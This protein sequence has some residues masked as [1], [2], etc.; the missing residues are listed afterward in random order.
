MPVQEVI[1]EKNEP[2]STADAAAGNKSDEPSRRG[3]TAAEIDT[4]GVV[5]V[6]LVLAIVVALWVNRS[7]DFLFA[8]RWRWEA[9]IG[10]VVLILAALAIPSTSR[11]LQ[12]KGTSVRA[13]LLFF[14]LIPALLMGYVGFIL[15]RPTYEFY[16]LRSLFLIVVILLPGVMFYL[17][18]LN[19][20]ISLLNLFIANL[21]GLGLLDKQVRRRGEFASYVRKFEAVY[22]TV[23]DETLMNAL[24]GVHD[25][26]DSRGLTDRVLT[27]ETGVP[28]V[29]ATLLIALGWLLVLP[30]K[31]APADTPVWFAALAVE[32]SP[33]N[34]AFL[35]AYFFALQMFFAISGPARTSPSRCASSCR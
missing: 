21:D 3:R 25:G 22:G 8:E 32:S 18:I 26:S 14:V 2:S 31:D 4:R 29:V 33:V 7:R 24:E 16:A 5:L 28:V 23:S 10:L 6:Y 35:G 1:T 34:F 12:E 9:A 11:W 17:F 13:G 20:K 15:W 19:R 30:L 27:A